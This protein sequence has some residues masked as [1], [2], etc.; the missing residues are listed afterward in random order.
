MDDFHS[1]SK[2]GRKITS[3]IPL[4]LYLQFNLVQVGFRKRL[5]RVC[6]KCQRR[7]CTIFH[8]GLDNKV[9]LLARLEHINMGTLVLTSFASGKLSP[10]FQKLKQGMKKNQRVNSL[11]SRDEVSLSSEKQNQLR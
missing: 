3:K 6:K 9:G 7:A 8:L 5:C 11:S 1:I 4:P 2:Y 10:V